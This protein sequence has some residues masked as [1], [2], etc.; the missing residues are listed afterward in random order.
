MFLRLISVNLNKKPAQA[1][2][3]I[4]PS[5]TK[6]EVKEYLTKIYDIP[7]LNV[8]TTNMLGKWKRFYGK[9]KIVAY[10]RRNIKKCTV[11]FDAVHEQLS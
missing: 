1:L 3:H 7:V 9:R 5:M 2:L 4:P 6:T 8:A 10:K 11:E